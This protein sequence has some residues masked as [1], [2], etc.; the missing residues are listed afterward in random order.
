[1][2]T[3]EIS[4]NFAKNQRN[5]SKKR[6]IGDF[7]KKLPPIGKFRRNFLLLRFISAIFCRFFVD[8]FKKLAPCTYCWSDGSQLP[9]VDLTVQI[10]S[11]L[12]RLISCASNGPN[13]N[14]IWSNDQNWIPTAMRWSNGQISIKW[15]ILFSN[16]KMRFQ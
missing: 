2:S 7:L 13:W 10:W 4:V 3:K 14:W 11:E 6:N 1:M 16:G 15:P 5:F 9:H 8:F 12:Q